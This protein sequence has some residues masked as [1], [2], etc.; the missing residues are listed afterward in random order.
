MKIALAQLNYHI[1]NFESNLEKII[2][3]ALSA[4]NSGAD[5]VV[6]AELAV[7]GYPPRDFLEFDDFIDRCSDA[8]HQIAIQCNEIAVIVGVPIRNPSEKGKPLFNSAAFIYQGHIQY[9]NKALLPNYDVFDEYRYFE[10]SREFQ[11]L[12]FKDK[13]IALTVCED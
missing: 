10:P 6:F 5:L 9:F 2:S 3:T 11:L 13:K 7:S 12:E 8:L 4:Q 1:G